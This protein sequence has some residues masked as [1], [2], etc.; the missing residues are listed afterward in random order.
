MSYT[1]DAY[2]LALPAEAPISVVDLARTFGATTVIVL[3]GN[4]VWPQVLDE[5]GKGSECFEEI[6]IGQPPDP[7]DARAIAGTRVFR[8]VCP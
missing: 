3:S 5:G 8:V 1:T 7:D 4:G 6:G 2:G